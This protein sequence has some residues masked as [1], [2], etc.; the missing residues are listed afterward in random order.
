M[1]KKFTKNKDPKAKKG[2]KKKK[3]KVPPIQKSQ[4]TIAP[5]NDQLEQLEQLSIIGLTDARTEQEVAEAKAR[6]EAERIL[7]NGGETTSIKDYTAFIASHK[8]KY[9]PHFS[10][11]KPY[12]SGIYRLNKWPEEEC[13][14]FVKR[15]EVAEWTNRLIYGRF[16]DGVLSYLK[17]RTPVL[18]AYIRAD[19]LFR[20][21][22]DEG[23]IMLDKF[24]HEMYE[25]MKEYDDWD[26][27]EK[28]YC[29]KYELAYQK[30]LI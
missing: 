24:I 16:P 8:Q 21:L 27:F 28:D 30:K 4:K 29:E 19:K 22:N 10:Y 7:L 3:K 20:Y 25:M 23:Q 6:W 1:A 18:F 2:V 9:F 5:Q 14:E 26:K 13:K 17:K 11:D 12:Y 15:P